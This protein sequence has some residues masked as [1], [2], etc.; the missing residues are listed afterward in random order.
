MRV[1]RAAVVS[2]RSIL[3]SKEY[4]ALALARDEEFPTG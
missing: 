1:Q 4:L 3:V 2:W